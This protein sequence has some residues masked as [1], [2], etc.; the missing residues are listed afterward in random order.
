MAAKH[1]NVMS[2]TDHPQNERIGEAHYLGEPCWPKRLPLGNN[3]RLVIALG[4][5]TYPGDIYEFTLDVSKCTSG[6]CG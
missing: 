3:I 2:M 5:L 6:N 1:S 4:I